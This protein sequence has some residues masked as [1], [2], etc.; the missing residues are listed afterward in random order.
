MKFR[1]LSS[2]LGSLLLAGDEGGL[3]FVAFVSGR[4]PVE[5]ARDWERDDRFRLF[6]RVESE[7]RSY[8]AG[9]LR[10]F[11]VPLAPAGTPFQLR[12]WRALLR[13][14]YGKTLS[15]TELARRAGTPT[16]VR[17]AGSANARN[18]IAILI[19]CH[20]V[21]GQNGNLTGYG[22]GLDAKR[23]LLELE[24]ALAP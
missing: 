4:Y 15:Y 9:K 24:G 2:P 22:G 17:A 19:P 7:L 12:V 6:S 8:F 14:P 5:P 21:V 16:A 18:P 13:V 10:S 3:R 11:S 1:H 20:R 23:S